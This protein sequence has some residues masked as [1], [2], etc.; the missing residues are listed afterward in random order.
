M[1]TLNEIRPPVLALNRRFWLNSALCL[2][3]AMGGW[4]L[5]PSR[6]GGVAMV[7][8]CLVVFLWV[9]EVIP[10]AATALLIPVVATVTGLA[11]VTTALQPFAHPVIFLFLGSFL[12]AR[13]MQKAG[14]DR[15]L[16]V[17]VIRLAGPGQGR[18]MLAMM[19]LSAFLSMWMS[20]TAAVAMLVPMGMALYGRRHGDQAGPGLRAM[21]L[22]IAW[23]GT[24]GG[25]G[26]PIGTPANMLGITLLNEYAGQSLT[27]P[28]WFGYGLPVVILLVP[29]LWVYLSFPRKN[30]EPMTMEAEDGAPGHPRTMRLVGL[31]FLLMV[32]FWVTVPL[33]GIPPAVTAVFFACLLY[34][35]GVLHKDDLNAI[36]WNALLT[37]GGGL[38]LGGLIVSTGLSD[39]LAGYLSGLG[40]LPPRV[41]VLMISL[42][43][44][45]TGA[46]ISNTACA[47]MLIPVAIPLAGI[48]G[49]DVRLLVAIIAISSS[50][51]FALVVG[52]PP[53][54]IAYSTGFFKVREIFKK[55]IVM[56]LIAVTGINLIVV[57]VWQ[58]LG[59][60]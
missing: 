36:D 27:F 19:V 26:S 21:I 47:A 1:S 4:W 41:V 54:M 33:H 31:L 25:I 35:A 22:A 20:N 16:A 24:I 34:P 17:M 52:T 10:L 57:Q 43:T 23:A 15:Q 59:I 29:I 53:T 3:L 12:M 39:H 38:A 9:S 40:S 2:L 13:A 50:V 37:F 48:L 18:L 46:L 30:D 55:G 28:D 56:D 51:D 58:W 60:A 6:D 45:C 49:L 8:L 32:L 5:A 14:L 44:V 7:L 11:D 42:F